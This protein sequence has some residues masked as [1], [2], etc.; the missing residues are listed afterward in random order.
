MRV[1]Y[2]GG[3]AAIP[4]KL[5][6]GAG[7][8]VTFE[9]DGDGTYVG[10]ISG[11]AGVTKIGTGALTFSG[12]N[13]YEGVTTVS[14]GALIADPLRLPNEATSSIVN[15][16]ALVF[17]SSGT[18]T[19]QGIISGTGD[20]TKAGSGT[21]SLT[22][23]HTFTGTTSIT[24]GRLNVDGGSLATGAVDVGASAVLG[25]DLGSIGGPVTVNGTVAPGNS[26]GTLTV[27]SVDFALG[28][29]FAV[30]VD[31]P[32]GTADHLVVVGDADIGGASLQV[33]PGAGSY[34]TPVDVTIL[35]AGDV[36]NDFASFEEDFPFLDITYMLTPTTVELRI[37]NN[38]NAVSTFAQTPNQETI[39]AALEEALDAAQ[40]GEGDPDIETVFDSIFGLTTS[41]IPR[42]RF[43]DGRD[44]QPVRRHAARD[45]A[46]LRAHARRANPR[47]PVGE[48]RGV[49]QRGYGHGRGERSGSQF[50]VPREQPDLRGGDARRGSRWVPRGVGTDSKSDSWIRTWIDG[51]G[52]YGRR[53]W[54]FE[55][56]RL[57]LHDLGWIARSRR[58]VGR[59][60]GCRIGGWLRDPTSTSRRARAKVRSTPIRLPSTLAT[61]IR[62]ST[63]GS[64]G[65]TRTT[66]WRRNAEISPTGSNAPPKQILD[67][68]DFGVRRFESGL[69]LVDHWRL[70]S[71]TDR[72]CGLHP[73]QIRTATP[74]AVRCSLNLAVEDNDLDS[75]VTGRWN[76]RPRNLGRIDRQISR[77]CRSCAVAGYT[78]SST[79]TGSSKRG[80]SSAPIGA[81]AFRI[82]GVE[83]PRDSGS[84]GVAWNVITD[85]AWSRHRQL[86]RHPERRPGTT[87]RKHHPE[88]RVVGRGR[89]GDVV[90]NS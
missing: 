27:D 85:S 76:A 87:R 77:S 80:W 36:L 21:L 68:N 24:A 78:N 46:A 4:R 81:S 52:I 65:A 30:E 43:D 23:D 72:L 55:L 73:S 31:E 13:S 25:G 64:P 75:L 33:D 50:D 17:D 15:D 2:L 90:A 62:D 66:T 29:V 60:L 44:P 10:S 84:I 49:H 59:A 56:E 61:S 83:L 34:A 14:D 26:V 39:A 6:S 40:M 37:L 82:Q 18:G 67:G 35:T 16:A 28:S 19:Y 57:R 47:S 86:R 22:N 9:Q 7:T 79:P 48:Q 38:G 45:R 58:A 71:A 5:S 70:H 1:A 69:N 41:Q 88:L 11:M 8:L 3:Y 51:S 54:R 74:R 12:T 53:R 42:A 89:G 32:S 20:F 63:S